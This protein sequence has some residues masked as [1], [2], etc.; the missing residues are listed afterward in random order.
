MLYPLQPGS[1]FAKREIFVQ[2]TAPDARILKLR[3]YEDTLAYRKR[4]V[5]VKVLHC[6][7]LQS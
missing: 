3:D 4:A 2:R 6:R 7:E 1:V 5:Q